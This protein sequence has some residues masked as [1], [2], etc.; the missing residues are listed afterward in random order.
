MVDAGLLSLMKPT[1]CLINTARGPVVDTS[2]LAAAL[3]G[4]KIACA[5]IDVFDSDPP[6]PDC[7]LFGLPNVIL[8]P[9]S[10]WYSEDSAWNIRQLIML[11]IDRFLAGL[12]PRFVAGSCKSSR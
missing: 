5:G 10:A 2:A 9:H 11:E 3:R 6:G 1:A 12:P 4:G 8:T 7:P